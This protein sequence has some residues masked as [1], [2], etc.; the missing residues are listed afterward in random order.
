ML[1]G[2]KRELEKRL[3]LRQ[4]FSDVIMSEKA[5]RNCR[6][7]TRSNV[8]ID[9]KMANT[10]DDWTGLAI[11]IEPLKSEIAKKMDVDKP[12]RYALRVR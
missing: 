7:L 8:C 6:L 2:L 1:R 11:I 4:V 3:K 12:G 10:T 5:C 9:C